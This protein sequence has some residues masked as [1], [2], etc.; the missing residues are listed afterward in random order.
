MAGGSLRAGADPRKSSIPTELTGQ[1]RLFA[2]R[3]APNFITARRRVLEALRPLR[4]TARTK[5][6]SGWLICET[7]RRWKE[8][9]ADE[10]RILFMD[11][12]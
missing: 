11:P 4:E 7:A 2:E 12:E 8:A 5:R 6:P 10:E 9:T 1:I 3:L